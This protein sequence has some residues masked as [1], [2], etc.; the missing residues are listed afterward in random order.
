MKTGEELWDE[1]IQGVIDS[2]CECIDK[3]TPM[4][5]TMGSGERSVTIDIY[6]SKAQMKKFDELTLGMVKQE[7]GIGIAPEDGGK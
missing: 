3:G 4:R 5:F 2:I 7:M 6:Q 1:L